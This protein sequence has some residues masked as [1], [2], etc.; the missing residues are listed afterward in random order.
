MTELEAM[1]LDNLRN[2]LQTPYPALDIHV[3]PMACFGPH[4]VESPREDAQMLIESAKRSGVEKM[5]IFSLYQTCPREPSVDQCRKANDY[6]LAMRDAAPDVFTPFCY[7]N[8]M[9]PKEAVAEIDRCVADSRMCGIKLWVAHRAT[10]PGLDLIIERA[11]A[12]GIP[13]LQHAWIK[14]TG[15]LVGE[16]FPADVADLARRHP[17]AQIVMAHLNGCGLRGIEDVAGC[18]NVSVDT[19][20]GD[21]ESGM[22]EAAVAVLGAKRVLY[23]SDAPIRHFGVQL[24]KTLGTDLPDSVK[25]DI[26]WNNAVRLLP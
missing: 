1:T 24:G 3:H 16:S 25:Q 20:G 19:S 6:V 21:P 2:R 23:G 4:A 8:P 18:P 5:C 12:L 22:V 15:N 9:Y 7:V 14:T 13:V 11:V 10:D 26:L 17:K